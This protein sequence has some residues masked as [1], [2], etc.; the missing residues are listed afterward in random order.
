MQ[1]TGCISWRTPEYHLKILITVRWCVK[2]GPQRLS[3]AAP[4]AERQG[5]VSKCPQAKA[6]VDNSSLKTKVRV[7]LNEQFSAECIKFS[8]VLLH[9]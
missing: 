4:A 1:T 3:V 5:F 8:Y 2:A 7:F 9:F 6:T